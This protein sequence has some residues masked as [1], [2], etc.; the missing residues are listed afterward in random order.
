MGINEY[1]IFTAGKCEKCL[2]QPVLGEHP[3]KYCYMA[4]Q[5]FPSG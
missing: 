1:F 4:L 3:A 5:C 2:G